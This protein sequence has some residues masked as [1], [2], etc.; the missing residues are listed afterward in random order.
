MTYEEQEK[1]A[2]GELKTTDEGG[3]RRRKVSIKEMGN[4]LK[5][6]AKIRAEAKGKRK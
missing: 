5:S 2:A 4:I 6:A 1:E 3:C